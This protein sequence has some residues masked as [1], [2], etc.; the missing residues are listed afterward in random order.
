MLSIYSALVANVI[1]IIDVDSTNENLRFAYVNFY[2]YKQLFDLKATDI[3][4]PSEHTRIGPV[5]LFKVK[6]G[7][8]TRLFK[9]IT[10]SCETY[11]DG[12][13]SSLFEKKEK[14]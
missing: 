11:D 3:R 13:F 4:P 8:N 2:G 9:L 10:Q 1:G 6:S 14:K 5:T 12:L 7:E